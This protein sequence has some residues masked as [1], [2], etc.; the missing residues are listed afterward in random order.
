MIRTF[1]PLVAALAAATLISLSAAVPAAA[2]EACLS[3]RDLQTRIASGEIA[4]VAQ[5]LERNGIGRNTEVLSV[6]V[7]RDNGNWAYYVGV[8]D[9]YGQARTLVL[10]ASG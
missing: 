6:E 4:P 8:I 9:A 1:K 3:N 5:V 2:Q 7:C 10:R